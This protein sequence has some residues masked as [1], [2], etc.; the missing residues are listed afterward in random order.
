[1]SYVI[2]IDPGLSGALALYHSPSGQLVVEDMPTFQLAK[3]K[4]AKRFLDYGMVGRIISDWARDFHPRAFIE[5][6]GV[7][8][9]QGIASAFDFGRTTGALIQACA[10]ALISFEQVTPQVW[11]RAMGIATGSGKDASRARASNLF[12]RHAALFSRVKDDGRAEAAL[13][14]RYGAQTLNL[15]T[16]LAR[17]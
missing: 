14:A 1:M 6:V 2:G 4:K 13:I 11:K 10:S 15:E 17:P 7:M 3:G 16:C 9:G 5:L 8:P 12:P